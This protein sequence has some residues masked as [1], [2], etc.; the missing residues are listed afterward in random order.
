MRVGEIVETL[1]PISCIQP[2]HSPIFYGT[3]GNIRCSLRG[4][5]FSTNPWDDKSPV[6]S[7]SE[8]K[9]HILRPEALKELTF[10][11]PENH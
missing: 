4:P 7:D 6:T 2:V 10:I 8:Q 5:C 9:Q 11:P 1:R 3:P